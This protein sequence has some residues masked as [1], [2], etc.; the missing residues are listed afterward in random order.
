ME[1]CTRNTEYQSVFQRQTTLVRRRG[2]G[3]LP[4]SR[5]VEEPTKF[6]PGTLQFIN[7]AHPDEITNAKSIRLIRSH[8]AKLSRALQKEKKQDEA[9]LEGENPQ[10][11]TELRSLVHPASDTRY[12]KIM[13]KAK[14][15]RQIENRPPSPLQLLGGARSDAYTGFARPLSHDE[16]YLFDF[17]LNYVISYGYTACYAQDDEQNFS[18][19]MRHIWVPNAMSKLSLMAAV[20]QVACRNYV[21]AT[22][23]S[24]SSKFAVKKLQY[25]LMCI[26]MA[27]DAIESEVVAT[28]TTIAL[29]MLMA[30]EAF[31]EGDMSAYWSH[32]AG[33]M[34]MVRARGGVDMLG[35]SGFLTRTVSESIYLT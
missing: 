20:F 2:R 11:E 23:N 13:P 5:P 35:M 34:K 1:N 33:V 16:H 7:S 24:L 6:Q 12:R 29:A 9:P 14:V 28:D 17:Y 26:Q 3:R 19:L 22:N 8:A 21:A 10:A 25:R 31:L 18:Y 30:S 4:K 27:K 15:H 32:G